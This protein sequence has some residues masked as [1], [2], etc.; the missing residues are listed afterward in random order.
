MALPQEEERSNLFAKVTKPLG[1]RTRRNRF[2]QTAEPEETAPQFYFSDE[3]KNSSAKSQPK[4]EHEAKPKKLPLPPI[5]T[6]DR[7]SLGFNIKELP[8]EEL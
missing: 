3:S 7:A 4:P 8:S 5:T 6:T 2:E 1:Q